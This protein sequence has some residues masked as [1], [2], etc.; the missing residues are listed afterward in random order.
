MR[1]R[2]LDEAI[3]FRFYPEQLQE[4]QKSSTLSDSF[5]DRVA[6]AKKIVVEMM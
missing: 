4:V 2:Q 1:F 6:R 3:E 5:E